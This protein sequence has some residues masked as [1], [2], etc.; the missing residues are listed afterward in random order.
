MLVDYTGRLFRE[1]NPAGNQVENN[2]NI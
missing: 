1:R 2:A